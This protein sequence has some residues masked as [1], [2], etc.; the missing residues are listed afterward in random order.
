MNISLC[1]DR[2]SPRIWDTKG[3]E[4]RFSASAEHRDRW[5]CFTLSV[6][7]LRLVH[8]G[9]VVRDSSIGTALARAAQE[10]IAMENCNT[11]IVCWNLF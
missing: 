3:V 6:N 4:G 2:S 10:A 5:E 9:G 7:G 1:Q 8:F 11:F